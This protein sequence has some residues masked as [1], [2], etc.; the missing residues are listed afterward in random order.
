MLIC[1]IRLLV[2]LGNCA[3]SLPASLHCRLSQSSQCASES[4][5][6]LV[7]ELKG[8]DV[9]AEGRRCCPKRAFG[10][11]LQALRSWILIS[12][13]LWTSSLPLVRLSCV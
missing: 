11:A 7:S 3:K 1:T 9:G 2:K 6:Y 4:L 10:D 13:G 12:R 8:R 5:I